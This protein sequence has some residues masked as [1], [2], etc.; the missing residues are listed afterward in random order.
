MGV[1]GTGWADAANLGH[2]GS[3]TT[4]NDG[5]SGIVIIKYLTE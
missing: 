1:G 4:N 2:G 5:S 3:A